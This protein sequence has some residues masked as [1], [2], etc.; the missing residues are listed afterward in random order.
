MEYKLQEKALSFSGDSF[1]VKDTATGQT[2]F[3]IKGNALSFHDS[4]TIQDHSGRPIYKMSES[5]LSLRHRMH[6]TDAQTKAPLLTTRQKSF[7]PLM[8]TSTILVWRGSNDDGEPYLEVKGDFF[9]KDFSVVEVA[10][11]RRVAAVKR[12]SFT[13]Q[14]L[15]LEK[16]TYIVRVEPG[17]DTALMVFLCVAID[18][19][20][21]DD[22]T[23]KGFSSRLGGD[24]F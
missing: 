6:I 4:K 20:H 17:L 9:R 7:I 8:G 11:G 2:A 24:I 10:S 3:K 23:R 13:L 15:L 12:K 16:D 5:L 21:R 22:G 1:S 18:E 14:N 19:V